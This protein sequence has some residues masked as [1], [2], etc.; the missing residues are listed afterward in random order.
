MCKIDCVVVKK[1][2]IPLAIYILRYK[3]DFDIEI[4]A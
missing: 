1:N 2:S 3:A 4:E